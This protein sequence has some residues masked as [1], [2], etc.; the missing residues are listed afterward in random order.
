MNVRENV[1]AKL[2]RVQIER[3]RTNNTLFFQP[4]NT[5]GNRRGGKANLTCKG[6]DGGAGILLQQPQELQ[7]N[8]V[9]GANSPPYP[10]NKNRSP[11]R[12]RGTNSFVH[13]LL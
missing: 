5:R 12:L 13:C 1:M 4:L 2:Q 6:L 9:H 11:T 3:I 10:K 7:I 8:F